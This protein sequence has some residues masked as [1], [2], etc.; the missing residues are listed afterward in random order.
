VQ[1]INEFIYYEQIK[2]NKVFETASIAHQDESYLYLSYSLL[3]N[4]CLFE[5]SHIANKVNIRIEKSYFE[6]Y[7]QSF[8]LLFEK[9]SIC[10]NTQSKLHEL[11]HCN[12]EGIVKSVFLESIV[13]YLLFQI[14]K[15]N[16]VFNLSCSSCSF[17][18]RPMELDKIYKAKDY[19]ISNIEKNITIPAVA[20]IVGTNQCYL[21]KGFKEVTGQTIF[22]FVQEN[23]MVK[24]KHLLQNSNSTIQDISFAVGYASISS[25]SQTYKNY[26]GIS[27]SMEQKQFFS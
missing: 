19:I 22:E 15:N 10:C 13:L 1:L 27:P 16:L 18:N 21:K 14:Q 11:I 12:L 7:Q 4:D 17:L 24:A 5:F 25:F 8:D 2:D 6:K 9:Q 3:D 20:S 23:R 26:Y